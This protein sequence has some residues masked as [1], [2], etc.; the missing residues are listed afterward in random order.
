MV[1]LSQVKISVILC[2]E[3]HGL[4]TFNDLLDCYV[5]LG[6]LNFKAIHISDR[7]IIPDTIIPLHSHWNQQQGNSSRQDSGSRW[8]PSG[9]NHSQITISKSGMR[10]Y[11][12]RGWTGGV[13]LV[14]AAPWWLQQAPVWVTYPCLT[15]YKGLLEAGLS[16]K[17]TPC[18]YVKLCN[19]FLLLGG[20]N[21]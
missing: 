8:R 21:K 5:S 15:A 18:I 12:R 1:K 20:L 11:W 14:S 19:S 6:D 13:S 2:V 7:D 9:I 17:C 10:H 16:L 3:R 4:S